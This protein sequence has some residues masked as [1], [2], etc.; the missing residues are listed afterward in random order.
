MLNND[1]V[2]RL[3]RYLTEQYAGIFDAAMVDRHI[4]DYID[5]ASVAGFVETLRDGGAEG[6]KL[7]DVGCGYG[8]LVLAARERGIDAGGIELAPFEVDFACT[9]LQKE[10]PQD[11]AEQVYGLGNAL[12]LPFADETFDIVTSMNVLEHVP[13]YRLAIAEAVRVLKRGGILYVVAPNYA[14]FR[15]EAHYQVPWLPFFPKGIAA[16][17]L[18]LLGRNPA[19]LEQHI[20][21]CSNWGV[22]GALRRLGMSVNALELAKLDHPER[23][24]NRWART[25]VQMITRMQL[26]PLL[27]AALSLWLFSPI[28]G[29]ITLRA[30]KHD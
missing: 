16:G 11:D 23:I 28:K 1:D 26:M 21:Y 2:S 12:K 10:R 25:V 20:Y 7:L 15:R 5:T 27:R 6:K 19:F 30:V 8:A 24:G 3:R 14:A 18:K 22:L 17:Y 29:S 4:A 13:D 9:R